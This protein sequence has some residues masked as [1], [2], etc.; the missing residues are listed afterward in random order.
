[1][2][3]LKKKLIYCLKNSYKKELIIVDPGH[4]FWKKFKPQFKNNV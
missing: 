1:M 4:W 2:I 3:F